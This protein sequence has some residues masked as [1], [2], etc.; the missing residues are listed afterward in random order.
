[1]VLIYKFER[2]PPLHPVADAMMAGSL[3]GEAEDWDFCLLGDLK[4]LLLSFLA[5][6]AC[7]CSSKAVVGTI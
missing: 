4:A 5:G 1:M 3:T 2:T 6:E 7:F